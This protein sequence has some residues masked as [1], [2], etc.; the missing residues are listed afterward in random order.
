MAEE[1]WDFVEGLKGTKTFSKYS[2]LLLLSS[3]RDS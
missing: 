2:P 3:G 1:E